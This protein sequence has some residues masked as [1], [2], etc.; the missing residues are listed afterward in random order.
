MCLGQEGPRDIPEWL[1]TVSSPSEPKA[2][3]INHLHYLLWLKSPGENV[4]TLT[5]PDLPQV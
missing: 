4:D 5:R 2:P 3:T 1:T